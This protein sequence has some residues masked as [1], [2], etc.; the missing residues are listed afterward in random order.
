MEFR[1]ADGLCGKGSLGEEPLRSASLR[2][3]A[4]TFP[5]YWIA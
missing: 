2:G 3:Y 1:K 4:P 5:L